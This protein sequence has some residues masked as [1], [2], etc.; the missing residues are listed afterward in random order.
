MES[1]CHYSAVDVQDVP[2]PLIPETQ[3]CTAPGVLNEV[4]IVNSN[5]SFILD[6]DPRSINDE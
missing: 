3:D 6:I 4:L 2:L 1:S 5:S